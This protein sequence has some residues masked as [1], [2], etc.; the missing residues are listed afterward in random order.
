MLLF[1]EPRSKSYS[2]IALKVIYPLSLVKA[3]TLVGKSLIL[4]FVKLGI[5]A[6]TNFL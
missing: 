2:G 3:D 4:D 1:P 6:A 5:S